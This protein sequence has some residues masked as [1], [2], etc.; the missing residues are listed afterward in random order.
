MAKHKKHTPEGTTT[1]G[2]DPAT[3]HDENHDGI[4][5]ETG[6]HIEPPSETSTPPPPVK[7]DPNVGTIHSGAPIADPENPG[8]PIKQPVDVVEDR[9]VPQPELKLPGSDDVVRSGADELAR[10][11]GTTAD[12]HPNPTLGQTAGERL[13]SHSAPYLDEDTHDFG[14]NGGEDKCRRCGKTR[15]EL[16]AKIGQ[17]LSVEEIESSQ[18]SPL[19]PPRIR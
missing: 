3:A 11:K 4:D 19:L 16:S 2:A 12:Y 10:V 15:A 17:P 1:G 14:P 18:D 8:G 9:D 5:D 6:K 7:D 13:P